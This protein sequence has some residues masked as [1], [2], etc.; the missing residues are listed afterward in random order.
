MIKSAKKKKKSFFFESSRFKN[1]PLFL[2]GGGWLAQKLQSRT[3]GGKN[4]LRRGIEKG[5]LN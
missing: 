2:M 1:P 5:G 3:Q 4:K